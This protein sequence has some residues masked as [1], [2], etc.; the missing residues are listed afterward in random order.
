M[1]GLEQWGLEAVY[2]LLT[3]VTMDGIVQG[4]K[5]KALNNQNMICRHF[6]IFNPH[7]YRLYKPKNK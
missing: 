6:A 5:L 3:S 2:M 1:Q 7:E 4:T